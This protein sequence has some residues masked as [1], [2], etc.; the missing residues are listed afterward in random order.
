MNWERQSCSDEEAGET[1]LSLNGGRL[2]E[3]GESEGLIGADVRGRG[4]VR[5]D[6]SVVFLFL[7][8]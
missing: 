5:P 4:G 6:A 8:S 1:A 2:G 7:V 3:D